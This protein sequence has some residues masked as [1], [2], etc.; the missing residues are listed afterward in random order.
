MTTLTRPLREHHKLCDE[1]FASTEAALAAKDWARADALTQAFG[2]ALETHFRCEEETLFP[3]FEAATGN[4]S[5]PTRVMRG[6]H[7]QMRELCGRLRN[8]LAAAD[9]AEFSGVAETL[10][11]FMQQ[12][13]MKEE[14]ILYPLCDRGLAAEEA[15]LGPQLRARLATA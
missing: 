7:A 12:H 1:L 15:S 4:T 13:N 10:L 8:A 9:A 6:E 14:N 11:I 2:A 5:G 3:A